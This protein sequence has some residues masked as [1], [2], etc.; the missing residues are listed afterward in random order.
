MSKEENKAQKLEEMGREQVEA[1]A[2]KLGISFTEETTQDELCVAIR[3]S[4]NKIDK[5]A[6]CHPVFG[7]YSKVIVY[8]TEDAQ[9]KTSIFVSINLSTFEFQP[10]TEVELPK[11]V[12]DFIKSATFIK[13]EYDAEAV[14]ENGNIGAHVAKHVRKYVVE[15]A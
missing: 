9:K 13:H 2:T 12:I 3:A 15:N 11:C 4:K 1:I 6:R 5:T 7:E 10:E 8:P 14:S